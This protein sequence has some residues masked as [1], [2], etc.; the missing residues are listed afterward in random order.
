MAK[1]GRKRTAAVNLCQRRGMMNRLRSTGACSSASGYS[2]SP[3]HPSHTLRRGVRSGDYYRLGNRSRVWCCDGPGGHFRSLPRLPAM[4]HGHGR[5]RSK[6]QMNR[7]VSKTPTAHKK[8]TAMS[9][10]MPAGCRGVAIS[11]STAPSSSRRQSYR[12]GDLA[13]IN[14]S[15]LDQD[16][17]AM[18]STIH[19]VPST[20]SMALPQ[21]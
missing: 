15:H 12:R 9:K 13:L 21:I 7:P 11:S 2:C 3:P 18:G 20:S 8:T 6:P 17:V 14:V 10:R 19:E 1:S 4:A 5:G 16:R